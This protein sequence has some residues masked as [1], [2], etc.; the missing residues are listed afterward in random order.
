MAPVVLPAQV[1][2]DQFDLARRLEL[3]IAMSVLAVG[4]LGAVV[5][6]LAGAQSNSRNKTD[7]S[8]VVLDQELLEMFG[9]LQNFPSATAKTIYD[10][11]LAAG[12]ANQHLA[13]LAAGAAP[14]GA[15][16]VLYTAATAPLPAQV[17]DIDWT[18]PTPA[19]ATAAAA[20]YAM[21]YQSCNGDIYEVRWNIMQVNFNAVNNTS[22][23]SLLT[24]SSR[25]FA[26]QGLHSSLLFSNPTT[27]R[28]M[29]QN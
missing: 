9:T 11:A 20:G 16:A 14:G 23:N 24:V 5:M 4:M 29:I 21:R 26:A 2:C 1:G 19:L 18:Q 6:I 27:L 3:V 7:S 25:Q 13:S 22:R 15:G 17:G 8:A 10:C 12:N 28:T